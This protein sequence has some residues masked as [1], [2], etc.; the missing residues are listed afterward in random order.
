MTNKKLIILILSLLQLFFAQSVFAIQEIKKINL[1]EAINFALETNPQIKMAKIDVEIAKNNIE[2]VNALKNPSIETFQNI[3]ATGT[4]NPQQI[5]VDYVVEI[6]KRGKRK[7]LAKSQTNV[8]FAN[9]KFREYKLISDVKISYINFLLK[10]S[11]LEFMNEQKELA[12]EIYENTLKKYN[13]QKTSKT[14]LIQAKIA[15][16]RTV[17]YSNIA[18]SELVSAQNQFNTVINSKDFNYD[19][20]DKVLDENYANLLT[21]NP[22]TCNLTFDKIKEFTLLNRNDLKSAKEKITAAKNNLNVVKSSLIPDLEIQGGYAYQ[23]KGMSDYN[24]FKSGAY[25][26]ASVVNIPLIYR[27]NNEIKNAK[28]EIEKTNLA[29]LDLEADIIR[30]ITDAWEKY[31]IAKENLNF[32]NKELLINSKE[33]LDESVKSLKN[34]KIDLTDFLVSKKLY[35]ETMLAYKQALCDYYVSFAELLCEMNARFDDLDEFI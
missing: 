19:T 7:K 20:K 6:L 28:L 32:Y 34:N 8:I 3:G 26:S 24:T 35:I 18:K 22:K 23:T 2:I 33:L 27:Y 31:T 5:G 15:F 4:G 1:V 14:E 21:L 16:N 25:A 12:R 9:Q 30:D 10:K 11:N 29:Y 13:L 17:L